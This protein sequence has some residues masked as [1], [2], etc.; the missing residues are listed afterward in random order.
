MSYGSKL[1]MLDLSAAEGFFWLQVP[2][3]VPSP[4]FPAPQVSYPGTEHRSL[5]A[6][7]QSPDVTLTVLLNGQVTQRDVV[8]PTTQP[9]GEKHVTIQELLSVGWPDHFLTAENTSSSRDVN[10]CGQCSAAAGAPG[11]TPGI[12]AHVAT[13]LQAAASTPSWAK[14][15]NPSWLEALNAWAETRDQGVPCWFW[16]RT[17]TV[18]LWLAIDHVPLH[19]HKFRLT[20]L[21]VSASPGFLQYPTVCV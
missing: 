12:A 16:A 14:S 20:V 18:R 10:T 7:K 17:M 2:T 8:F 1:V 9:T 5:D 6:W 15:R 4:C 13:L 21:Q 19:T 3:A 11:A